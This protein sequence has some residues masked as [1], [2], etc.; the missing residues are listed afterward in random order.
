MQLLLYKAKESVFLGKIP[1]QIVF[2]KISRHVVLPDMT[3]V[4][5]LTKLT[6]CKIQVNTF[7][8]NI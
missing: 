3:T 1:I 7:G 6:Q 2:P 4:D 8:L 5:S